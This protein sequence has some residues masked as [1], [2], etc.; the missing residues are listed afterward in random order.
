MPYIYKITNKINGKV[1]IGKTMHTV[2]KRWRQ[3]CHN[4]KRRKTEKRPL[5]S[6]MNKYGVE[7][8][9]IEE[10][11]ECDHVNLNEREKYW[12]QHFNS[13]RNGYNA[14]IGGDGTPYVDYDLVIQTYLRVK[15]QAETAKILNISLGTVTYILD[16][17]QIRRRSSRE[18]I[19]EKYSKVVY[20]YSLDGMFL[21]SFESV[22]AAASAI[23]PTHSQ[24]TID[25]ILSHIVHVCN[26]QR[27]SAYGYKWSYDGPKDKIN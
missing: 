23:A 19:T 27:K 22:T 26:G 7:N 14:T 17:N 1:Y 8:F 6:A 21:N 5:Y 25:G 3:H 4:Y 24:K 13:Y 9:T 16:A 20:M 18:I 10:I 15:N 11:E 12:I 2:E